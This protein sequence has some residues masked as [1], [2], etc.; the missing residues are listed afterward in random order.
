MPARLRSLL[1]PEAPPLLLALLAWCSL[2]LAALGIFQPLLALLLALALTVLL[3]R[4]PGKMLPWPHWSRLLVV[5]AALLFAAPRGELLLGGW[6]PGV[7][8]HSAAA[9]AE[10][11]SLQINP[12]HDSLPPPELLPSLSRNLH[13][14]R[15]LFP[16]MRILP[17]GKLSPQ[18]FHLYPSLM[19]F[20]YRFAGIQGALYL[21]LLL[22]AAS[23]LSF[24]GLAR[25]LW[26]RPWDLAAMLL[27][28]LNP[29][30]VWASA[31]PCA[32]LLAQFLLLRGSM[33]L[34]RLQDP[35]SGT[36]SALLAG[37]Y[38]GLALL[39]R[40]DSLFFLLPLLS[41]I[42]LL[43]RLHPE[44]RRLRLFLLS[45]SLL[46][47]QLLIHML[48]VA[49]YYRPLVGPLLRLLLIW[50]LLL[51]PG[52]W[53]L[54]RLKQSTRKRLLQLS[55]PCAAT[56][57]LLALILL[58]YL[59]PRIGQGGDVDALLSFLGPLPTWLSG[60]DAW[61][62]HRLAA[63]F[64]PLGLLLAWA[65]ILVMGRKLC[66]A[67]QRILWFSAFAVCLFLMTVS[68]HTPIMMWMSRRYLPLLIPFFLL[69]IC[70]LARSLRSWHALMP[71]FLLSLALL[72]PAP[73]AWHMT[74][75]RDWPGLQTWLHKCQEA[76]PEQALL[77]SD[78]PGFAAALYFLY[79]IEAY[80]R[81]P[82][83]HEDLTA[84]HSWLKQHARERPCYW[85]GQD[86]AAIPGNLQMVEQQILPLESSIQ[87]QHP[88][89]L[90]RT[91]KARQADF[92]LMKL[93][94]RGEPQL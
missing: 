31:F 75:Q 23:V 5:L 28:A 70:A 25:Q 68:F 33:H 51:P 48:W 86:S 92:K 41:G 40:M 35:D 24:G 34:L 45:F 32:E 73:A 39:C 63:L 47:L 6:D 26:G 93:A 38:L 62:L 87:M 58:G 16:G 54:G 4:I 30:Q 52:L 72:L 84:F 11:G 56:V 1:H 2:S 82:E 13:G 46:I 80:E 89:A 83:V 66:D 78:Q 14:I 55:V 21:N 69:G 22:Y 90:P 76:L 7:Y 64:H 37:L 74:R 17:S 61:N 77:I 29:A 85:L 91:S 15:E 19:A 12:L 36:R 43:F 53:V 79:G 3:L 18:F 50:A 65:G 94:P 8:L 44:E 67:W 9:I 59:R 71:T 42:L 88:V 10:Q 81:A 27:L 49:P 20:C 57:W 60:S